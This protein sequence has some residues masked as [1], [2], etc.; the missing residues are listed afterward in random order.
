MDK[1]IFELLNEAR[2]GMERIVSGMD[3]EGVY[4]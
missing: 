2:D 4:T 1:N 3:R